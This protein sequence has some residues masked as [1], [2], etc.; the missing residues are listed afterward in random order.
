MELSYEFALIIDE[1][2]R[3]MGYPRNISLSSKEFKIFKIED[4]NKIKSLSITNASNIDEIGCL[5]NLTKLKI[6]GIDFNSI[7]DEY[8]LEINPYINHITDFTPIQNLKKLEYLSIKNDVNIKKLSIGN[9]TNLRKLRL[10]NNP[11]LETLKGLD[12]LSKLHDVRIYGT[13]IKN[14]INLERYMMNTISVENN[15][16]DIKIALNELKRNPN[17]LEIINNYK[18]KGLTNI[19]FA[20]T[21][22]FVE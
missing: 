2:L 15:I 10:E 13:N 20:E 8:A 22:G 4:L 16:I 14:S 17:I 12:S 9:L 11:E 18:R 5:Q 19:E 6:E 1:K 21:N 7:K 3:E